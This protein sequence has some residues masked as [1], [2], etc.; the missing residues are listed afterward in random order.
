M[1]LKIARVQTTERLINQLQQNIASAVEPIF[2]DLTG[3]FVVGLSGCTTVP[4]GIAY[5]QRATVGGPI[6]IFFPELIAT[7]NSTSTS[8]TGFPAALWPQRS[9]TQIFGVKDNGTYQLGTITATSIGALN[10]GVGAS[11]GAFT[12]SGS[13]GIPAQVFTYA[14][15][16]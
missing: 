15:A 11:S 13:K 10:L 4:T 3:S 16:V 9:M 8:L 2:S 1:A 6:T 7:S 14:P 12:G 5:W